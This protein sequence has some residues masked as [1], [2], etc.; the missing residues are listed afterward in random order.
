VG[1]INSTNYKFKD[2]LRCCRAVTLD[3]LEVEKQVGGKDEAQKKR[4]GNP[5]RLVV[6]GRVIDGE[7]CQVIT[8]EGKKNQYHRIN[9]QSP[10]IG[11]TKSAFKAIGGKRGGEDSR[12]RGNR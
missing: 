9:H 2:R 4:E 10:T 7:G 11:P 12:H 5:V 6:N 3:S 8:L 1:M